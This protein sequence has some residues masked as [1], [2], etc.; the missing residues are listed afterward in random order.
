MIVFVADLSAF[1]EYLD[2]DKS[3]SRLDDTLDLFSYIINEPSLS[4]LTITVLLNKVDLLQKKLGMLQRIMALKSRHTHPSQLPSPISPTPSIMS[5][6]SDEDS[7]PYFSNHSYKDLNGRSNS[8]APS[9]SSINPPRELDLKTACKYF[10]RK[11]ESL[12]SRKREGKVE[13]YVTS[14]TS[15]NNMNIVCTSVLEELMKNSL[16]D[17][18]LF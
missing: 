10:Q 15:S 4:H 9:I 16:K 2:E 1:D 7:M 13:F 14:A 5:S 3:V 18:G 11:F 6:T 17:Y 8:I 12:V